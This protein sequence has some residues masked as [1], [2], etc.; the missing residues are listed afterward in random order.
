[1]ALSPPFLSFSLSVS[2]FS[3]SFFFRNEKMRIPTRVLMTWTPDSV[4]IVT[5]SGNT[6]F[7]LDSSTLSFLPSLSLSLLLTLSESHILSLSLSFR[8]KFQLGCFRSFSEFQVTNEWSAGIRC[9]VVERRKE[10]ERKRKRMKGGRKKEWK[11]VG[12]GKGFHRTI[13]FIQGRCIICHPVGSVKHPASFASFLQVCHISCSRMFFRYL[14][15]LISLTTQE[16]RDKKKERKSHLSDTKEKVQ[17]WV[18][19]MK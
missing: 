11:E 1:M 7:F 9:P 8:K 4:I 3:I 18:S 6:K 15:N 12:R 10:C 16:L 19:I 5:V 2:N 13:T 14:S 17:L